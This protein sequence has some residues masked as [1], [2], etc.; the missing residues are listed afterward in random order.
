MV[1]FAIMLLFYVWLMIPTHLSSDV[2]VQVQ[3]L[4]LMEPVN[5]HLKWVI[6]AFV[7]IGV[8]ATVGLAM[9]DQLQLKS[10]NRSL[11]KELEQLKEEVV[12]LRQV[13]TLDR[14]YE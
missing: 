3:M 9:I 4:P 2:V 14:E 11:R 5:L 10:Q 13:A 7:H 6:V 1:K 8:L 12:S